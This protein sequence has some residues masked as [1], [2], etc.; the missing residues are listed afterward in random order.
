MSITI[1]KNSFTGYEVTIR[2]ASDYPSVTT[3]QKHLRKA[4][5]SDCRSITSIYCD[6]E[7]MVLADIGHGLE[8]VKNGRC[9]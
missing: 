1:I 5:A 4:K 7:G 9:A 2:S 3:I 6:G 8:L